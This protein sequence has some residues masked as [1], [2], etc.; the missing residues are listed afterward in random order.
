[1]DSW[2]GCKAQLA[3]GAHVAVVRVAAALRGD[4]AGGGAGEVAEA[5]GLSVAADPR[6]Q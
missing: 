5:L 4:A 1:M 6:L 3:V 2:C